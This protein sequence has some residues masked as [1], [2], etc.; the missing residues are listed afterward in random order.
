[1]TPE[2]ARQSLGLRTNAGA[3]SRRPCG[4]TAT[5]P[6]SDP[7]ASQRPGGLRLP[8]QRCAPHGGDGAAHA[9]SKVYGVATFYNFFT[10]KPPGRH[11]CVVCTGTACYIKGADQIMNAREAVRPQGRDHVARRQGLR[12]D[13]ALLRLLRPGAGGRLDGEVAGQ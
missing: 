3:S 2:P 1:M 9:A 6:R 11:T 7:D 12:D 13:G 4:A 10:L 8:R 5:I